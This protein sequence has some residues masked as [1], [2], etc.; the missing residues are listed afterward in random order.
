NGVICGDV[1]LGGA[2]VTIGG[3]AAGAG[4][5]VSGNDGDGIVVANSGALIQ[6]NFIGTNATGTAALRNLRH[7]VNFLGL[8]GRNSTL[9]GTTAGARNL[10]SGNG[11]DGVYVGDGG[12]LIQGNYIGTNASGTAALANM[13]HGVDITSSGNT[14]GGTV[15]GAR[16]VISGNSRFGVLVTG[17]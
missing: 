16:N 7:G 2:D 15:A 9:G 5:L 14:V 11:V 13:Q 10:I 1:L 3:T 8:K 6:G 12:N 4:N 17:S